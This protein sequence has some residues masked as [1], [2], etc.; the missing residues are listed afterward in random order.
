MNDITPRSSNAT[1]IGA[2]LLGKL[3]S[4]IA[5]SRSSTVIA[6]GKPLLRMLKDSHWVFGQR[7]DAVQENSIWAVNPLSIAHGWVCWTNHEGTTKNT[8]V[9]EVMEPVHMAKP[10][11]PMPIDD[12]AFTE[13]RM[14]ELRCMDGDDAGTEVVYK[15]SSVG[16]MRAVDDLL[17]ALQTQLNDNPAFPCP[18]V[19]LFSDSYQHQKYGKIYV[20]VFDVV[21]WASM[22]GKLLG[23]GAPTPAAA[24]PEPAPAPRARRAAAAPAPVPEEPAPTA[25]RRPVRR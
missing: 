19:Q 20:P 15:I 3:K 16:G 6:G 18:V 23:E 7:D 8:L 10:P 9:G 4:G 13:Q 21:D 11:R 12:W 14:F 17:A 5:E 22:D 1:A 24:Q 25:R 2:D